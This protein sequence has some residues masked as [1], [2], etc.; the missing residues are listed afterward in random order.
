MKVQLEYILF[1]PFL[2]ILFVA[3][4]LA[5]SD[6]KKLPSHNPGP[7]IEVEKWGYIDSELSLIKRKTYRQKELTGKFDGYYSFEC[8]GRSSNR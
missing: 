4:L 7:W 8:L 3:I 5:F 1:A 6:S 2:A